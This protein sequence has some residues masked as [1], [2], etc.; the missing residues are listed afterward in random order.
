MQRGKPP[1]FSASECPN[2]GCPTSPISLPGE[3][4]LLMH[5][6]GR[7]LGKHFSRYEAGLGAMHRLE[8]GYFT[9]GHVAR[10]SIHLIPCILASESD[11]IVG[12]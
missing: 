5:P 2:T 8:E 4:Q 6:P 1:Q 7:I 9:A 11:A 3:A 10:S 12:S